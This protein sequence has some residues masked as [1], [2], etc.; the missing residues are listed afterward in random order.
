MVTLTEDERKAITILFGMASPASIEFK[1]FLI[2]SLE[3][4]KDIILDSDPEDRTELVGY[5]KALRNLI[6]TIG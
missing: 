6:K 4:T 1:N 2:R 5:A 3:E